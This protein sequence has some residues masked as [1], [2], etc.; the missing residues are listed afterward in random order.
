MP[1]NLSLHLSG[2]SKRLNSRQL[3]ESSNETF[4]PNN[5]DLEKEYKS[6]QSNI[7]TEVYEASSFEAQKNLNTAHSGRKSI[8]NMWSLTNQS[9]VFLFW[10]HLC[11][12][13]T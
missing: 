13:R 6:S 9:R 11:T 7:T 5:V 1:D 2:S 3:M 8:M 10:I 4:A 12:T